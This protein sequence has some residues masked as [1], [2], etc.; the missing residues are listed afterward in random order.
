M[1]AVILTR[2]STREQ[3]EGHS[4]P[5]QNTRL[6]DYAK[7]KQLEVIKTFQ[8]IESSTRGKRKEF[9]QMID[10]CKEQTETIAIIADAVDRVQ[11]SFK[12]SVML[13]DLIRQ[14]K[15]ELHFFREGMVI[16][17]KATSTDIMRWDFSVMGAKAYVLQLSENVRRSL[18]YKLKNGERAGVAPCGYEN[19]VDADGK[20]SIRPKEPDATKVRR[21]FEMY[22]IGGTSAHQ[23]A[24]VADTWGL[25]SYSGKK[26]TTTS[27]FHILGNP[28]YYGEMLVKGKLHRHIYTPLISKALWDKVQE[29]KAAQGSKPF[30]YGELP[31]LY[32]GIFTDYYRQIICPCEL[33]KQKFFYVVCYKENGTRLYIPEREIDNQIISILN[34]IAIPEEMLQHFRQHIKDA[35][36][37]EVDFRNEELS[38]LKAEITKIEAR[39]EKLFNMRLDDEIDKQTYEDKRD[40]MLLKKGRLISEIKAHGEADDGFNEVVLDLF[41]LV[42]HIGTAYAQGKSIENKQLLLHF[43][44]KKLVLKEGNIGY[45]LNAPFCYMESSVSSDHSAGGENGGSC[46]PEG[47]QGFAGN[48]GAN[49]DTS[50]NTLCEP[51]IIIKKQEV[52]PQNLTSVQSGCPRCTIFELQTLRN[53]REHRAEVLAIKEVLAYVREKLAA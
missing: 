26:L 6:L 21:L 53:L 17:K 52:R 27:I 23:L 16:G 51:Q 44:F 28:F 46:E 31:F 1:K 8:I 35:K 40:D 10:F 45:E 20:H 39:L 50:K 48:F 41:E 43:I 11:R 9:M 18:D 14:E 42:S 24:R 34:R 37:S 38:R 47:T 13:D 30:K 32:R 7:R 3:E 29:Q 4:L 49:F 22:S 12:E 15:I 2:V 5:A 19:F 33:K 25:R 36:Q